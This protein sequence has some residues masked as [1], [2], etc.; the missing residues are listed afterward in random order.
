M[1]ILVTGGAG[2][3]GSVLCEMLLE[4]N[5]NWNVTVID[6]LMYKQDGL[7]HLMNNPRLNFIYGDVRDY[8]LL[9]KWTDWADVVIPLA[10]LVGAPLCERDKSGAEDIN[11]VAVESLAYLCSKNHKKII[12]PNTNSGYGLGQGE[13]ECTEETPLIPISTYGRT[14]CAAEKSVLN[15]GGI[16]FRLATVFGVSPRM[17]LDLLVNDFTFKAVTD[18]YIV[19]FEKDFKRN[20]IHVRDVCSAFLKMI[21]NYDQHKGQVFNLGLSSANLSKWELAQVIKKYVPNFSIQ[22]DD[23]ATDPDKRNYIVSNEKMEKTGWRPQYTLDAGIQELIKSYQIVK[24]VHKKYAN[25]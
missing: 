22:V 2:Y 20:Y 23:I 4:N 3:I 19:L 14:K 15:M 18:G 5:P 21:Y 6:S 10:A 25:V 24:N 11:Q 17:R 12:Y 7:L 9:V 13:A 8:N 16:A 1:N